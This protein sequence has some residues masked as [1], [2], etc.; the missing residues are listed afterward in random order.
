M[1]LVTSLIGDALLIVL[2]EKT[3]MLNLSLITNHLVITF[4]QDLP[5][6]LLQAWHIFLILLR[7]PIWQSLAVIFGFIN[8][9]HHFLKMKQ[10]S[11]L[12]HLIV[13]HLPQKLLHSNG[14]LISLKTRLTRLNRNNHINEH[15]NQAPQVA[16]FRPI[17]RFR[18]IKKNVKN[19]R[20]GV[21]IWVYE[22]YI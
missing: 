3:A 5:S 6:H 10:K 7:D 22:S 2:F 4:F 12:D 16:R 9:L 13:R 17:N 21:T 14:Y 8:A 20:I 19:N 15:T 11:I 18:G 1:I